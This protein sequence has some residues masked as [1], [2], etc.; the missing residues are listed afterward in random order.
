MHAFATARALLTPR[1]MAA[2]DAAAIL[3][4]V[5]ST[6]LV[7]NA[8]KAIA[9]SIFERWA[10]RPVLIACGPGNNGADG[11]A[12]ATLLADAGWPVRVTCCAPA[13]TDDCRYHAHRYQG[14]MVPFEATALAGM[15]LIVDGLFGAGLS[16]PLCERARAFVDA[17]QA[18]G[19]PVVAIDIPSGV[20]GATGA[21]LGAAA[22]ATLTVTFVR[23]KPGHLLFPGRALCGDI[24]LA[25]IGIDDSALKSVAPRTFENDPALWL[26]RWPWPSLTGHKYDRGHALIFGG[27]MTGA[28][29]LVARAAQRIGAGLVSVAAPASAYSIYAAALESVIVCPIG[30]AGDYVALLADKRHNAL[31]VGPGAGL[32]AATRNA[33]LAALA[34]GRPIV[35]D[36]DALTLFADSPETLFNAIAGPC[37]M[38]P[39]DGEFARLFGFVGDRL[40]RARSA[41]AQSGAIVVLKG[42]DTVIAAPE[43]YAIINSNAPPDLATGGAG[44]VLAGLVAGAMAQGV[45]PFEAAAAAVWVHGAA[46]SIVG[47]GLIASDL[48]DAVPAV[49]RDLKARAALLKPAAALK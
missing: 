14:A 35:L 19:V 49:L 36:A 46:A 31:V 23:K 15:A 4:G 12:L 5:S 33:A 30:A 47:P 37:V 13:A 21:V 17:M 6:A 29:R 34:T 8:A 24:V 3:G 32:N 41:A 43:G 16:R 18:A 38:T 20:E 28:A 44:D 45:D 2:V 42:A 40:S 26:E 39:H 10:P 27:E 48:P 11:Y 7:A 9:Q 22:Q 1:E 25:D